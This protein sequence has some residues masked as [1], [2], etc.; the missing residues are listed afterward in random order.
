MKVTSN[1]NYETNKQNILHRIFSAGLQNLDMPLPFGNQ[2][3]VLRELVN[4]LIT[5][6]TAER[7]R[8]QIP[9]ATIN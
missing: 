6:R 3:P 8:T 4:T 5:L 2:L 9:A 1:F 7:S